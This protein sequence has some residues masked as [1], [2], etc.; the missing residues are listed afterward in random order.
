MRHAAR[1][2]VPLNPSPASSTF[3]DTVP[4]EAAAPLGQS[5]LR[6]RRQVEPVGDQ[7]QGVLA[8]RRVFE[9]R[10]HF[11]HAHEAS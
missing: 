8:L 5:G 2:S 10:E 9:A 11:S 1:Q 4:V 7:P 3:A 6:L